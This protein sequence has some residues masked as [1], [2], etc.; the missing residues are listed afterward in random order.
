MR[1]FMTEGTGLPDGCADY[2]LV[3]NILHG[4]EPHVLLTEA[5]R[6]LSSDGVLGIMHWRYDPI[7]PRGPSLEI[8]PRPEQCRAWAEDVGF[9]ADETEVIDLPPYHC[10][11][12]MRK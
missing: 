6:V 12:V 9:S 11:L 4:E 3:F 8:R 10:G 7:T 5:A 2:A 1:D